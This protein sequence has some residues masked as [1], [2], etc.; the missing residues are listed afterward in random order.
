MDL[1]RI[2]P[3]V[4]GG[5]GILNFI[6]GFLPYLSSDNDSVSV[7][8]AGPGY[9]PLAFLIAGL[10]ALGP[11]L[12]KGQKASFAVAVISVVTLLG[13]L[14]AVVMENSYG[15]G[16]SKGIGIILLL[17]FGLFQ[18]V[19]AIFLWLFDAGVVK[20]TSDGSMQVSGQAFGA[21][22]GQGGYGPGA[23]GQGGPQ[24]A[25]PQHAGPQHGGPQHAGPQQGP[26]QGGPSQYGPSGAGQPG[27][28]FGG[29]AAGSSFGQHAQSSGGSSYGQ[30]DA[31]SASSGGYGG[32][33]SYG[34][35][36]ESSGSDAADPGST[37]TYSAPSDPSS[38]AS[39][40]SDAPS[41]GAAP[42]YGSDAPSY[43]ADAPSY[44]SGATAG[45]G[46]ADDAGDSEA[47]PGETAA[48][49]LSKPDDD[50]NPD[51]TQQVRF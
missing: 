14:F 9:L 4:V 42:S 45:S 32:Q 2:L 18:A 27:G 30:G 31:G 33:G 7:F 36:G 10:L 21:Q 40:S 46:Q 43:G 20:S 13:T 47:N 5:L 26:G 6:M 25:G 22:I 12:P 51:V 41:Y 38:Y 28:A 34:S 16:A 29:A 15:S 35:Y 8:G 1:G 3:M 49:N 44:G 11:L 39:G 24:H 37:S 23:P 50:E 17:I 48:P 19:A